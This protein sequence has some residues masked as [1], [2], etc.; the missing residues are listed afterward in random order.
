MGQATLK[1]PCA[2]LYFP[3]Y[4]LQVCFTLMTK[5]M[6]TCNPEVMPSSIVSSQMSAFIVVVM[7][8]F[9]IRKIF[10]NPFLIVNSCDH[11]FNICPS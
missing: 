2:F 9:I 3:S 8:T 6:S 10:L 7:F 1:T 4:V 11:L 5:K